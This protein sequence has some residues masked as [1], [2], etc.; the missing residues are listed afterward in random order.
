MG[1]DD[2]QLCEGLLQIFMKGKKMQQISFMKRND[3]SQT[4]SSYR[5]SHR[6]GKKEVLDL[7]SYKE[8][9]SLEHS[10]DCSS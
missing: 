10:G 9:I 7:G 2:W 8:T 6:G 5:V 1:Q 4:N 3:N